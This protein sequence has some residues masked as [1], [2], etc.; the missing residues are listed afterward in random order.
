MNEPR[1]YSPT[2]IVLHW[3]VAVLVAGQYL[4]ND[5][6]SR[7]WGL[8][9]QGQAFAFEPLILAHIA[10]GGLILV[11][12]AW[13]VLLRLRHGAPPPPENEP[14]PLKVVSQVA[15]WSF[16]AVLA[17]LSISGLAAWFGAI[18]GAALAH[19]VLKV[20]L[21]ALIV[22]HM[23]AVPFHHIVLKNNVMARMLRPAG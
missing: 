12:V 1:G 22:L 8:V 3:A 9:R 5:A 10:V 19:N 18:H 23:L 21:L 4:F 17:A 6:I 7:A 2:Q 20:A 16:Y 11:L 13:R 15:H 14:G